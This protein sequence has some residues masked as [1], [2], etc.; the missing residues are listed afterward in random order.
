MSARKASTMRSP[1]QI[2]LDGKRKSNIIRV[3]KATEKE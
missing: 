2:F 3:K 1:L